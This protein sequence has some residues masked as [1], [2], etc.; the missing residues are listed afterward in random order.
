MRIL[1]EISQQ[2]RLPAIAGIDRLWSNQALLSPPA[3]HGFQRT[4][5][6]TMFSAFVEG[7]VPD[8][9]AC[10]PDRDG[11]VSWCHAIDQQLFVTQ[12]DAQ[13]FTVRTLNE[14]ET[15]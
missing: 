9:V 10:Q 3:P 7:A 2:R 5:L 13:A 12:L 6:S 8:Q 15:I 1:P 14:G 4:L 11:A